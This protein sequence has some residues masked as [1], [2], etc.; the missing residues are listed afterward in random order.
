MRAS[1]R[2]GRASSRRLSVSAASS[3]ACARAAPA[4]GS[5]GPLKDCNSMPARAARHEGSGAGAAACRVRARTPGGLGVY[6]ALARARARAGRGRFSLTRAAW[7]KR[8]HEGPR[9]PPLWLGLQRRRSRRLCLPARR[10]RYASSVPRARRLH[11]PGRALGGVGVLGRRGRKT[12]F[13][14]RA[15]LRGQPGR[16]GRGPLRWRWEGG[17]GRAGVG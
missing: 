11:S 10:G 14:G 4:A 16:G 5:R 17:A 13:R 3:T 9:A 1:E 6:A 12:P 8:L 2:R 7:K 15:E